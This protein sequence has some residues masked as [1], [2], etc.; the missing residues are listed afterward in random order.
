MTSTDHRALQTLT[1]ADALDYP[2]EPPRASFVVEA[3]GAMR[4]VAVSAGPEVRKNNPA[5]AVL[6]LDDPVCLLTCGSNA[7]PRRLAGK[8]A[9]APVGRA[10]AV[11]T[12]CSGWTPV[13]AATVSY[14][15]AIPATFAAGLGHAEPFQVMIDRHDLDAFVESE[16]RTGNY[17][18]RRL[19][20]EEAARA[21]LFLDVPV[22]V[23][24]S[25]FAPLM[26]DGHPAPLVEFSCAGAGGFSQAQVL[27]RMLARFAA[28]MT[29]RAYVAQ[30][31]ADPELI[32]TFRDFVRANPAA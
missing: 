1:V 6:E 8:L 19:S 28:G 24:M 23:F 22:H 32:D 29:P 25:R 16:T 10:L 9:R 27:G 15:G 30:A 17:D 13:Y 2:F 21:G 14:Y 7:S 18:L 5:L 11:R 31:L 26:L 4:P 20:E 12:R 3:E